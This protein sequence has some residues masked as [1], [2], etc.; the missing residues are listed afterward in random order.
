MEASSDIPMQP[1]APRK[2]W[3]GRNWK[4]FVPTGCMTIIVLIA[5]FVGGIFA[6]VVGSMKSSDAYTLAMARVARRSAG[7]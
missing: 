4:W 7:R 3:F 5:A 6:L 2:G 1:A